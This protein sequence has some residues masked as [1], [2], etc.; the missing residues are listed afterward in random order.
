M[1]D[2]LI[3]MM[4]EGTSLTEVALA[5]GIN[6]DTMYKWCKEDGR[7]FNYEFSD[8]V[9]GG[10]CFSQAW[11]EPQARVNLYNRKFNYHAWGLNMR[12]RFPKDWSEKRYIKQDVQ[13]TFT[14]SDID[15]E[16]L[17]DSEKNY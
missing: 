16:L 6:R 5:I 8:A 12:M 17:E 10:K 7:Y 14:L 4:K 9:S 2:T 3:E 13:Q 11:W 15:V 1:A